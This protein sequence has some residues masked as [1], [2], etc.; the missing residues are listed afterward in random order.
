MEQCYDTVTAKSDVNREPSDESKEREQELAEQSL[1]TR[2][3]HVILPF[4]RKL[5][6]GVGGL[7][8]SV[9]ANGIIQAGT[10]YTLALKMNMTTIGTLMVIPR[11]WDSVTDPFMGNL[12]DNTRTRWG[13]RR[14]YVLFGGLVTALMFLLTVSPPAFLQE[15]GLLAY[16]FVFCMLYFTAYTVFSVAFSGLGLE[17]STEYHER[18][19]VMGYRAF[20]TAIG[21]MVAGAA[22]WITFRPAWS[23]RIG[24]SIMGLAFGGLA[25]ASFIMA[26][27]GT[28]EIGEIQKQEK[29]GI[30]RA[31]KYTMTNKQFLILVSALAL[32]VL[33][34]YVTIPL[35][36]VLNSYYVCGGD[37][38]AASKIE[39]Y[40]N[41]IYSVLMLGAIAPITW[42][43]T[44]LGK[45]KTLSLCLFFGIVGTGSV[46]FLFTPELPYLQLLNPIILAFSLPAVQVFPMSIMADIC[47]LDELKTGLRR[48]G[49]YGASFGFVIKLVLSFVLYLSGRALDFAGIDQNLDIQ[50]PEALFRLRLMAVIVPITLLA[51]SG[52]LLFK[53]NVPEAKV[54]EVRRILE[55]RRNVQGGEN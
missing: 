2:Q 20:F 16:F 18:T 24:M 50:A 39:L 44:R 23:P 49:M 53:L 45:Q 38:E 21:G 43:G 29:V 19:R 54:R 15:K 27:S 11:L 22:M 33:G 40:K 42:V 12:S 31:L 14:P 55:D 9:L 48:E 52:V 13:R 5:S 3:E 51:A 6:Y 41:T 47:D 32:Y 1:D 4:R 36:Q 25:V 8:D 46:W 17:M 34:L 10:L 35:Y 28:R 7:G 26:A 30:F 37:M